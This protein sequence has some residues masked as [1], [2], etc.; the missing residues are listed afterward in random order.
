MTRYHRSLRHKKAARTRFISRLRLVLFVILL[1]GLSI[2]IYTKKAS[3]HD[4]YVRFTSWVAMHQKHPKPVVLRKTHQ[5]LAS[6]VNE[7]PDIQF[8][9]YTALPNMKIEGAKS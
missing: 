1:C 8:E 9:F 5:A 4:P 2:F 3:F 6:K 7:T